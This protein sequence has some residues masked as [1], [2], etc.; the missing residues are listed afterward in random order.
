[1]FEEWFKLYSSFLSQKGAWISPNTLSRCGVSLPI[2]D[3]VSAFKAAYPDLRLT[4][5]PGRYLV[6]RP[7]NVVPDRSRTPVDRITQLEDRIA[8]LE[9][10]LLS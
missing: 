8:R 3:A 5:Y 2:E 4:P 1:M 6:T 9:K 10:I 7:G